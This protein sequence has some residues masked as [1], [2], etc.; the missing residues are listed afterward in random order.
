MQPGRFELP[1]NMPGTISWLGQQI[2]VSPYM[3]ALSAAGQ[4]GHFG[5]QGR[6]YITQMM[7]HRMRSMALA[8]GQ[9]QQ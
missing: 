6:Y 7:H 9:Q 8:A 2:G 3:L 1:H 4:S 5:N